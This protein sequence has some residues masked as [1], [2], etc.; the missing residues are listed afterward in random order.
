MKITTSYRHMTNHHSGAL[1][2][3]APTIAKLKTT[4]SVTTMRTMTSLPTFCH[5]H[6]PLKRSWSSWTHQAALR[7]V[8]QRQIPSQNKPPK[9]QLHQRQQ[10]PRQTRQRQ[11]PTPK[12][13]QDLNRA[14]ATQADPSVIVPTA[15]KRIDWSR[16]RPLWRWRRGQC[17]V[18]IYRAVVKSTTRPVT[19]KPTSDGT[20]VNLDFIFLGSVFFL[21]FFFFSFFVGQR[22]WWCGCSFIYIYIVFFFFMNFELV[23]FQPVSMPEICIEFFANNSQQQL[24]TNKLTF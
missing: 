3:T 9:Q 8:F 15:L 22:F 17:T 7:Q 19:W 16:T 6:S 4:I 20:Q 14:A 23:S 13:H 1:K 21:F 12:G 10:Q 11:E 5:H 18:V 2:A 24:G